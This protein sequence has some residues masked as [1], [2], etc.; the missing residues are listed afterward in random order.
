MIVKDDYFKIRV[1]LL[2]ERCHTRFDIA[3]LVASR[4]QHR[5]SRSAL[6]LRVL[7]ETADGEAVDQHGDQPEQQK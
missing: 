1:I 2:E 7:V 5:D 3:F 4:D 6:G